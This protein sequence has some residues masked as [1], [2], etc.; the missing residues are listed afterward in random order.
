M[1]VPV[2]VAFVFSSGRR[3]LFVFFFGA[4]KKKFPFSPVLGHVRRSVAPL[5]RRRQV[6]VRI[7]VVAFY[8]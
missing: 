7:L 4:P 3:G 5:T 1:R 8:L 6:A 2:R